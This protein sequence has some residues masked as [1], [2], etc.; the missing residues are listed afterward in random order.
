MII[1]CAMIFPLIKYTTT[2]DDRLLV[3]KDV[4]LDADGLWHDVVF[5]AQKDIKSRSNEFSSTP[6]SL[7]KSR[8]ANK[9]DAAR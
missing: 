4:C 6:A 3:M 7:Q 2:E 8:T 9:F 1:A 5:I